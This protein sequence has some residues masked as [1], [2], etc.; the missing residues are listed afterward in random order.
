MNRREF[1]QFLGVSSTLAT[2]PHLS[3]YSAPQLPTS[4]L[5]TFGPSLEDKLLLAD[6][7]NYKILV[8]WGDKI[9]SKESFGFNNDFIAFHPLDK[10][11]GLLWVNHEYV[12][13]IFIN[14]EER[15]SQ[16]KN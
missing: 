1:L 7:L 5:P 3:A 16:Q 15:T 6:G 11:Q 14:G 13:P 12:N 10:N 2:L 8:R 9:N 4:T